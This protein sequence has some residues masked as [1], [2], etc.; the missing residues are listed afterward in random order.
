MPPV[1]PLYNFGERLSQMSH[2][3]IRLKFSNLNYHLFN[4][5]LSN[6]PNCVHCNVPET[7]IHYFMECTKY[8]PIIRN[9]MLN[10][11]KAILPG[12]NRI[13]MNRVPLHVLLNG[14]RELSYIDNTRIF[15]IVHTYIRKTGRNP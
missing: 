7:P 8:P 15:D 11:V 4:Y 13:R 6:S 5:G 12:P 2:T 14:K 10:K 9:E 3:R 1:N